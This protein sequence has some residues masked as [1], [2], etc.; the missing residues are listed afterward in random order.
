[1]AG[2]PVLGTVVA[3]HEGPTAL[4][5]DFVISEESARQYIES[6]SFVQTQRG[7]ELILGMVQKLRRVNRYYSSPDIIHGSSGG[8]S[9]PSVYPADKWDY[10]IA[11]VRILGSYQGNLRVRATRPVLPGSLVEFAEDSI[12]QQFLGLGETGLNLGKVRQSDLTAVINID[13]LLQKHL[14][15]M[16]ISGGGKSY[17][18]SVII[19]E[20]MK[21]KKTEGRPALVVFDVHGEYKNLTQMSKFS[22]FKSVDVERITADKLSLAMGYLSSS[23]LRKFFPTMSYA[24]SRELDAIMSK[25]RIEREPITIEKIISK[26][27]STEMNQLVKDALLGWVNMLKGTRIFGNAEYPQLEKSIQPGKL[28]IIDLSSLTTLW[29]KRIILHY[30]LTRIFKL[31][32]FKEICPVVSFIEEA[33]QF[34]PETVNAASKSIIH[35]IARE[36]RKFLCSLVLISQRPVNLST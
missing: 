5:F 32:R 25:L 30:F 8:V 17:A 36:G 27:Y 18:T 2:V 22:H 35:T 1:M 29:T 26:I 11:S 7:E 21:R 4:D 14:A 19:E 12:L 23:D 15:I 28:L 33:H 34:A 10:V 20:L 24:Q 31:R 13:K 6:G 16:S 9:L 3:T